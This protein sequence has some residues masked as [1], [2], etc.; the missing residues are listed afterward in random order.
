MEETTW[1][2]KASEAIRKLEK[3]N[4][5]ILFN[6]GV[7]A[8]TAVLA[9]VPSQSVVIVPDDFYSGTRYIMNHF[10]NERFDFK[11]IKQETYLS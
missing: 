10:F 1:D 7:S 5:S 3:A 8:I 2:S 9:S 11:T 6:S 4:Y